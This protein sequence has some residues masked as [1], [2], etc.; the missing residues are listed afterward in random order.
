MR[1]LL[2]NKK[3]TMITLTGIVLS[4]AMVTAVAGFVVST[5]DMLR[6]TYIA[7]YGDFHI[8]I[9][10]VTKEQAD[11]IANDSRVES[12]STK[13]NE[14]SLTVYFRIKDVDRKYE[15]TAK[16][17]A[18]EYEV[19]SADFIFN[20]E[21]LAAEGILADDQSIR[22]MYAIGS[23]LGLI[24]SCGSIIVISNAFYI[25]SS[26]R[27]RQFGILKSVGATKQQ[28]R[29]TVLAE[30]I[31]LS[32]IGIPAG[33]LT[34]LV[35]ETA[36]LAIA[37]SMLYE[38]S[39]LNEGNLY[40]RVIFSGWA[41][42]ASVAISL[43]TV[44]L[45]AYLPAG[46]AAKISTIDAIRLSKEVSVKPGQV[47]T[48][49]VIHK[50][51]GFEGSLAAKSLKR[52]SGKY[53]ATVIS[54]VVSITLYIIGSGFGLMLTK[55][56][57]IVY[58]DYGINVVMSY[59]GA[60]DEKLDL[61]RKK[62]A[63]IPDS[64]INFGKT[65]SMRTTEAGQILTDDAKTYYAGTKLVNDEGVLTSVTL[66]SVDDTAFADICRLAGIS[67]TTVMQDDTVKGILV[68]IARM[69]YEGKRMEFSPF[70]YK[71]GMALP[72][73]FPDSDRQIDIKLAGS[74]NEAPT[75]I[76]ATAL[77]YNVNIILPESSF[78]MIA[79]DYGVE[80]YWTAKAPDS[81]AYCKAAEE[82]M[83]SVLPDDSKYSIFDYEQGNRINR[84][85]TRLMMTFIYG[86][87]G[88]LTLIAITSVVGTIS[89]NINL[90]AQ[91]FAVLASVGMTEAGLR[92]MLNLES[93]LYGLKALLI[94]LP[95]ALALY[96]L[97]YK[98]IGISIGFD[99]IWPYEG[100]LIS[101][102]AVMLITFGTMRHSS[103]KLSGKSIVETLSIVSI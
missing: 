11:K 37:N 88:M 84:D 36:A 39:Q 75:I 24:I 73:L 18:E 79:G 47:K 27:I 41:I 50:L 91:E 76:V 40:L 2:K 85:I 6:R 56:T 23:V 9:Y 15:Q 62:L 54:L 3:R 42:L 96:Y 61:I 14:E 26:E 67:E 68:N 83:S 7:N 89:T 98:A 87:V 81:A 31:V 64:E 101:I 29:K 77:Y 35:V 63:D 100:V 12:S 28:I 99:F 5:R 13:Q 10:P 70:I 60:D 102:I 33:V 46:R 49:A 17:I 93:L 32:I 20:K 90:R 34:G 94:G 95:L 30:G 80:A 69:D 19:E 16:K 48:F 44:F 78:R 92:R 103:R 45:S 22:A 52:S 25:S 1:Q 58:T 8:G 4:V 43:V 65:V 71:N 51:F 55:A 97:L 21:L 66:I 74:I 86:F 57:D 53:R 38:V 59:K 72:V 82:I